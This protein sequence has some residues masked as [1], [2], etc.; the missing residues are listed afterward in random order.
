MVL[1]TEAV[2]Y[3][4]RRGKAPGGVGL[5]WRSLQNLSMILWGRRM[6]AITSFTR[7]IVG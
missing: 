4:F 7:E 1:T 5:E 3:S 2:V 6:A